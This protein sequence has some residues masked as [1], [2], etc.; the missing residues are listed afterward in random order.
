MPASPAA[1]FENALRPRY[2]ALEQL[3]HE[4]RLSPKDAEVD[5]KLKKGLKSRSNK[6]SK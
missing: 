5:N 6:A 2:V 1:Q 4:L 3:A